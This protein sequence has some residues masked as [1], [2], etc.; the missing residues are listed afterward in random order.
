[1]KW[2]P[3][4]LLLPLAGCLDIPDDAYTATSEEIP[5]VTVSAWAETLEKQIRFQAVM[6]QNSGTFQY[7]VSGEGQRPWNLTIYDE[8]GMEVLY[9]DAAQFRD[10]FYD[11]VANGDHKEFRFTWDFKMYESSRADHYD[12]PQPYDWAPLGNYTARIQFLF[13]G[14]PEDSF[15]VMVPFQVTET[16]ATSST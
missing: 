1:M 12:E 13:R 10:F 7:F 8:A 11:S 6:E 3:V 14:V 16:F 15:Q 4:L 5:G 2:L 9:T